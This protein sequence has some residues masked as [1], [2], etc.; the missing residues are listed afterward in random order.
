[1]VQVHIIHVRPS[2]DGKTAVVTV[3]DPDWTPDDDLALLDRRDVQQL[4]DD[5]HGRPVLRVPA[6]LLVSGSVLDLDR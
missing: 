2:A 5:E 3:N 6:Q 1:M 4:D